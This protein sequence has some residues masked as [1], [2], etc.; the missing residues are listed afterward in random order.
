[1]SVL[2][3]QVNQPAF[4]KKLPAIITL[5]LLVITL[6]TWNQAVNS[7][8]YAYKEYFDFR[9]REAITSIQ[10]R[11]ATY[12]QVLHGTRGLYE[13][14]KEVTRTEFR[15]YVFALRLE[16]NFP[17]NQGVG[18][19]LVVSPDQIKSHLSAVRKEGFPGYNIRPEGDRDLFTAIVFLEPL[20]NR[21]LRAFG[22]D[23]FS[24]PV[25]REA[26][27]KARDTDKPAMS[28]KVRLVQEYGKK[29]QAGF[30]IYI[31]VYKNH[32]PHD[33]LSNRQ[34]SIIGWVYSPFRMD[35]LMEGTF[36][37]YS[38]DLDVKVYD[39]EQVNADA[40]MYDSSS[41]SSTYSQSNQNN[42]GKTLTSKQPIEIAGHT[43]TVAIRSL[44]SLFTRVDTDNP[45]PILIVGTISSLLFGW[46][47]W[48]LIT[49]R[50]RAL[51]VAKKMNI[52]YIESENT[53]QAILD[54]SA[55]GIAWANENGDIEYINQKFIS[56][57]GYTL[58]DIP[59]MDQWYIRAYPNLNY[60][61]KVITQWSS[62]VESTSHAGSHLPPLETEINC[63]DDSK[64]HVL[65]LGSWAGSKLLVNF[66]DITDR[67][68][69][70]DLAGYM[71]QHDALTGLPN[72]ILFSDRLEQAIALAKRE[73]HLLAILFIDLDKFKNANDT[74]GHEAG[75]GLLKEV[76][77]RIKECLRES[78]VVARM[79][80]DE[81]LVLMPKLE[82]DED[83]NLVA[84]KIR[85]VLN[86]PFI[87]SGNS[88][89]ISA[90]IG[91]A[92]YPKDGHDERTL[93]RKADS[94][95][96]NAKQKGRNRVSS[97]LSDDS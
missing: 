59:T 14:S 5:S 76:A 36:G 61:N 65:L 6:Y 40:I 79:G 33:T 35:D 4:L 56:M 12:Q 2:K 58:K 1:M 37:E 87:I 82:K 18:F 90:S 22:Y 73:K 94:A 53:L 91:I 34:S 16:E 11:M 52:Q 77:K 89:D 88:I 48:L 95:M 85:F 27:E 54:S 66:S 28:G 60:R 15:E 25:R 71:A 9:V 69:S 20:A 67:K 41:V 8:A 62:M 10:N 29:E 31:P 46:L 45:L 24:E 39:G 3:D 92:I 57:F 97:F 68:K 47:T 23:M 43:W 81:F 7:S 86:H 63:G 49:G 64:K 50:E 13:A 72:R 83:I 38:N 93:T 44:P 17:G 80:G 75:D 26:M 70:E 42:T 78:D 30:L 51:K 19:S 55:I 74:F 32:L 84:E 96:Y 21:N